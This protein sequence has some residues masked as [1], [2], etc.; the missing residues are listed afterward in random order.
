MGAFDK[1][2]S[3]AFDVRSLETLKRDATQNSP[4]AL[5]Q[6]AQQLEGIFVQ[7]MVKS[8]RDASFKDGLFDSQA[9]EMYTSMYDQQISQEFAQKG[10]LGFAEMIVRQMGGEAA[11]TGG[12]ISAPGAS[13]YAL[14]GAYSAPPTG[15]SEPKP[16]PPEVST[17]PVVGD[18]SSPF[19]TRML[20]PALQAAQQSGIHPHLILAQAALESGWG[21]REILTG[22]GKPSHNLFGIKA[23]GDWQGKTTEITTT[24]FINGEKRKVK[25]AFRVYDSYGEALADYTR[26][27]KNNPRYQHVVK[28]ASPEQGAHALQAGGYATDPAYA[29][30]LITIIQKVKGNIQQSVQ[31]YQTDLTKIF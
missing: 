4:H 27:L 25:A 24:E 31:A 22:E 6:A 23:T 15:F 17:A 12:S 5:K 19:I 8:M 18:R 30:K 7:M 2:S 26:L 16:G 14:A 10:Q 21:K 9:S 28:S 11:E 1:M 13:P 20:R 29:K 3:A